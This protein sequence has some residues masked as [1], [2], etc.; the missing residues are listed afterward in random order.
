MFTDWLAAVGS[1]VVAIVA[2]FQDPIRSLITRPR[3]KVILT[4]K[5]PD[6]HK[7][8]LARAKVLS[9]TGDVL[10]EAESA[11]IYYF[12]IRVRNDGRRRAEYVE[13]FAAELS[14]KRA[15]G[16][17]DK[18]DSFMP[19]DLNWSYIDKP[20][21]PAISRGMEKLCNLG[22]IIDPARRHRF[23]DHYNPDLSVD[24]AT[25]T[26]SLD[27]QVK[28][29]TKSHVLPPGTYR[30]KFLIGATQVQP[31]EKTLEITFS[32]EWHDDEKKMLAQGIGIKML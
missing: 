14:E 26:L 4:S 19:M 32:G 16:G 10:Q 8:V 18:M 22:S 20:I 11:D 31:I 15:D 3:L 25:T 1:L 13:V 24:P 29:N 5:P 30:L 27:T 28:P 17:F 9:V 6:F 7:I 21:M 12:R 2:V 23:P